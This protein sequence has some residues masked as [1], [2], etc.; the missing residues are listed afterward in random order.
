MKKLTLAV[1]GL[2]VAAISAPAFA[3]DA[4]PIRVLPFANQDGVGAAATETPAFRAEALRSD[5]ASIEASRMALQRS[6]NP[7]VRNYANRV[8][9]ER[10]ATTDALLP[11]NTS[12]SRSGSVVSDNQGIRTDLSN[13]IGLVLAPVTVAANIGTGIVGG[14]L[15]AVG[16]VDNNPA[17]PGRRVALG[18]RG[19]ARLAQLQ[20]ARSGR[21]FD[22]TYIDQQARSDARTLAL[23]DA[24]AKSGD[25][26]Q[27]R[28]FATEALP[29][30]AD[31][32]AHSASLAA[33]IGG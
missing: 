18:D 11:P 15:G 1:L 8:L 21:A 27:G 10:K 7:Q 12:L 31:E 23:Y 25:N 2:S 16:L 24:Y 13:P 14:A 20:A 9:V 5:A 26:A 32:H 17:E 29:Y 6:R 3:Q 22:R 4:L 33:R 19:Q 30:I 28:K